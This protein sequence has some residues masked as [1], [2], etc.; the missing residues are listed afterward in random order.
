MVSCQIGHSV[1]IFAQFLTGLLSCVIFPH[2]TNSVRP[3]VMSYMLDL[4]TNFKHN[5]IYVQTQLQKNSK[6][7]LHLFVPLD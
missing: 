2:E 3:R 6:L 7:S 5:I 4:K 1:Q